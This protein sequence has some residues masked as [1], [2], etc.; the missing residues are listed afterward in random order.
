MTDDDE[1]YIYV[2]IRIVREFGKAPLESDWYADDQCDAATIG[3]FRE[4]ITDVRKVRRLSYP[5]AKHVELIHREAADLCE[6]LY[7]G[8]TRC[9]VRLADRSAFDR[10]QHQLASFEQEMNEVLR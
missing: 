1:D 8:N 6:R 5:K 7:P 3:Y 10:Y 2:S 4:V 9:D